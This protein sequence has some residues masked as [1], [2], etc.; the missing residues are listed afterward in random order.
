M[1]ASDHIRVALDGAPLLGTRTGVGDVA[2]NLLDALV[3][4]GDVDPVVYLIGRGGSRRP[5]L[6]RLLPAGAR[7]G[8]AALP[9]RFVEPAWRHLGRPTIEHW[10]GA[11]DVVHAVNFVAPPARAPVIVTV[12]DLGFVRFP[13][14]VDPSAL[15]FPDAIARAIRRGARIHAPS[16]FVASEV[17]DVFDVDEDRLIRVPLGITPIRD[18]DPA[19]GHAIAGTSRYVL[20][21][22]TV[23]PRKNLP[24]LVAAFDI[25]ANDDPLLSL[26]VAGPD[27]RGTEQ[28]QDAID[29]ARAGDRVRRVGYLSSSERAD[30][31]TGASLLA[32]PSRYE[33]FGL[34]PLEAMSAGVPVVASNAGSLPEVLGDAALSFDPDDVD[35]M[36]AAMASVLGDGAERARLVERGLRWS[37]RYDWTTTATMLVDAYRELIG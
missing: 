5:D 27:G 15:E 35:A 29:R 19:R 36:A 34:P 20:A 23:E 22:G 32:Y 17:Q 31:L 30:V 12:Q 7:L 10:T 18:G 13:H 24:A 1:H 33:G 16:G 2:T 8:T 3:R 37:A 9:A 21:L 28:L 11:V 25:V 4:S 14:L 6:A 26:V